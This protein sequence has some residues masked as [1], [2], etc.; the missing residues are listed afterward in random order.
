ML[1]SVE[2][3]IYKSPDF[4]CTCFFNGWWLRACLAHDYNCADAE[5]Q[6]SMEMRKAADKQLRCDVANSGNTPFQKALSPLIADIMYAGVFL[7]SLI[8]YRW[9]L[10][11]V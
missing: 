1:D 10:G 5:A 4:R 3:F 8:V 9:Y 6:E 2:E 11:Y 7:Y